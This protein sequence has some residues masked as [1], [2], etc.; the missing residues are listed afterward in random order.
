MTYTGPITIACTFFD[1]TKDTVPDYSAGV[2]TPEW[3]D[4]LYRMCRANLTR[5]MRFVCFT[6]R[7]QSDFQEPIEC[8]PFRLETNNCAHVLEV[9]RKDVDLGRFIFMGLDTVIVGSLEELASYDGSV[10]C[11][12]SPRK[13]WIATGV[14]M[15]ET[16]RLP[17]VFARLEHDYETLKDVCMMGGMPSDVRLLHRLLLPN[18]YPDVIDD[19]YP[20]RVI[21]YKRHYL[22]DRYDLTEA[23][24]VY[25]HGNPRPNALPKNDPVGRVWVSAV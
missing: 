7:P 25:F 5:E 1:G 17:D 24:I 14:M 18:E 15:G 8:I 21:S 12:R 3:A 22:E 2:Y 20:G 11:I 23:R 10:A 19:L 4:R 16:S 13:G 6:N 9:F